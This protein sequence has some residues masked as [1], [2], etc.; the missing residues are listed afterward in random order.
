MSLDL[1]CLSW[2]AARDGAKTRGNFGV[3]FTFLYFS[4]DLGRAGAAERGMWLLQL[5]QQLLANVGDWGM[6]VSPVTNK[7]SHI[8]H[9]QS[10]VIGHMEQDRVTQ[11]GWNKDG[12]TKHSWNKDGIFQQVGTKIR[13]WNKDRVTQEPLN[14]CLTQHSEGYWRMSPHISSSIP[15]TDY[16][17]LHGT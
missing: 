10:H 2:A 9:V 5:L 7:T 3:R 17:E 12:V 14:T 6:G 13:S 1:D 15:L 11:H 8:G 16:D 4:P